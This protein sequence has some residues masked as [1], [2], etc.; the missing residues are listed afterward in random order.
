MRTGN[1]HN[2][3]RQLNRLVLM[4]LGTLDGLLADLVQFVLQGIEL[5]LHFLK[6]CAFRSDEQ[7][8]ILAP[9]VA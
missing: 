5:A 3:V 6:G 2:L 1:R 7:T 8:P 9:D 4:R